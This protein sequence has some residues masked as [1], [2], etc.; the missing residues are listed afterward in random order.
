MLNALIALYAASSVMHFALVARYGIA[1]NIGTLVFAFIYGA[2][3]LAVAMAVPH[4]LWAG[5]VLTLVGITGLSL[6]FLGIAKT[7]PTGV[8]FWAVDAVVI[9]LTLYLLFA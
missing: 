7:V 2:L 9:A 8:V 1:G 4:A 6:N 3:A 5:L